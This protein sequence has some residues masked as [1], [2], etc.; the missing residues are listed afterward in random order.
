MALDPKDRT[1]LQDMIKAGRDAVQFM[2]D[3]T[4]EQFVLNDLLI[5]AVERKI[6]IIGEAARHLST[7]LSSAHPTVPWRLIIAPR[8]VLS[9]EYGD[10]HYDKIYRVVRQYIPQMVDSLEKILLQHS[11]DPRSST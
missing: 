9:H 5:A 11:S 8:N 7:E 2:G 10:I 6:E 3:A 1:R 4:C